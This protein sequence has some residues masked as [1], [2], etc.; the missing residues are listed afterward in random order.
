M[1]GKRTRKL[2]LAS[3]GLVGF[4]L[5][6]ILA[7]PLWFPWLLRPIAGARGVGY[8]DYTR[9][10]YSRFELTDVTF[11]NQSTVLFAKHLEG[12]VPSIWL[13]R[14]YVTRDNERYA[15]VDDWKLQIRPSANK[16]AQ[17]AASSVSDQYNKVVRILAQINRLLPHALLRNG[18]IQAGGELVQVPQAAW[19]DQKL[20]GTVTWPKKK[21]QAEVIADLRP[22]NGSAV[23]VIS[24]SLPFEAKVLITEQGNGLLL[25]ST[26]SWL[27]SEF[28]ATAHFGK[29]GFTPQTAELESKSFSIPAR[30]LGLEGYEN[31]KGGLLAHWLT[32]HF[33][34]ELTAQASP[35]D[36]AQLP[37]VNIDLSATGNTESA[38]VQKFKM[39]A[40]WLEASL[41]E[42]TTIQYTSPYLT[43]Q[44]ILQ[45]ALNLEEQRW[46]G[47][48]GKLK[49][50][51]EFRPGQG[52]LPDSTFTLSGS[53]LE[54]AELTA[55]AQAQEN[56]QEKALHGIEV[57]NLTV[58]GELVWP[59]LR[60]TQARAET[61]DG[62]TLALQGIA[63]LGSRMIH[64]GQIS[65]Q[66]GYL[67]QFL[68]QGFEYAQ[69]K[70][71]AT[72]N[73]P[74]TNLTHS[75]E[76]QIK[77]LKTPL[78]P[79]MDLSGSW[80]G[81][82][83]RLDPVQLSLH[84]GKSSVDLNGAVDLAKEAKVLRM[85]SLSMTNAGVQ[86][87]A[88]KGPF[89]VRWI[90][91]GTGTTK[92]GR[93]Q[94]TPL[95]LS[96]TAGHIE[97]A[98]DLLWPGQGQLT[99]KVED[100]RLEAF[101][102]LLPWA[103]NRAFVRRLE[104]EGGW[105]NGPAVFQMTL[106]GAARV[107]KNVSLAVDG[108][109]RGQLDGLH[110]DAL[111]VSNGNQLV[112][113]LN[114]TLP[115]KLRLG[116]TNGWLE[117]DAKAPLALHADISPE[118]F[119]DYF[120]TAGLSLQNP[121]L[122]AQLEGTLERPKGRV[123]FAA[124]KM[125][126]TRTNQNLPPFENV[127]LT[128]V[129][130]QTTARVDSLSFEIAKQLVALH[131]ELPLDEKFWSAFPKKLYLPDWK[132]AKAEIELNK[133][134]LAAFGPYLPRIMSPEGE[135][136]GKLGLV[137]G[138]QLAGA[139]T[140]SNA[141]TYPIGNIGA[142]RDIL[143]RLRFLERKAL[144][145]ATA[146]VGGNPMPV[147][148][149][150]DMSGDQW[151]SG[152]L[153]PFEMKV[154]A[155]KAPLSRTPELILKSDLNVTVSYDG[156]T[157]VTIS[158]NVNLR[159]GFYLRD[160]S[161]LTSGKISTPTRRPPYFSIEQEPLADWRLRMTVT[162]EKFLKV[163]SPLFNGVV[164]T[165]LR[166]QGTLRE[167]LATGELKVNSG[168]IRF[169]FATMPITQGLIV[170]TSENP[171]RPQLTVSAAAR[172][173]G[174]DIKMD[175]SGFA[176]KPVIQFSSTPALSSEQI[177][178]MVSAGELPRGELTFS[179]TQKAQRLALFVG[180]DLL[181]ELGFS[182]D[183]NRLTIRSGEDISEAGRPTYSVEYKLQKD[184]SV[185]GEYDRFNDF[186]L[187]LKWRVFSR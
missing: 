82:Q 1:A 185:I 93:L 60:L 139:L 106:S 114:G 164:S 38:T 37:P 171:Y 19:D 11:T 137:P 39:V 41:S 28:V 143:V 3:G 99:A 136:S 48:K 80:K 168:E 61:P 163:R 43:D 5:V 65:Y 66:G 182:G 18:S 50:Q 146:D 92:T 78:A 119:A 111:S 68:P 73:G 86:Q 121:E 44:T 107:A 130:D 159:D 63:D 45:L 87:L 34:V 58:Q 123:E 132:K 75:G 88:S 176:D 167:P 175:L 84:L 21:Q 98:G 131:G 116:N 149:T 91:T 161:D 36:G 184:L 83:F 173:F 8:A 70:L 51:V 94:L 186:N 108:H 151:L 95:S 105:S 96:G 89:E 118:A 129:V 46:V 141:R 42:G 183:A 64:Y 31:V 115:V 145:E 187:M 124:K 117:T 127:R 109:W 144:I 103:T 22:G 158:G 23:R 53:G 10:G 81:E 166:L 181:S 172:T 134:Q 57:K 126:I 76:I 178:L 148:G 79:V 54:L 40:P 85:V 62:S 49:G 174:Y 77:A 9:K 120:K 135:I 155:A 169:P 6:L 104:F 24:K 55:F 101:A 69:T 59:E 7:M 112:A 25:Q 74:W 29:Q 97:A 35:A 162:G 160:L 26:N 90:P 17:R 140:V 56:R 13:W 30:E 152:Q 153:P 102:N 133:A 154:I 4:L 157:P 47:A 20:S 142:V 15:A 16:S 125:Q 128:G 150:I 72:M 71:S 180:K 14:L 122:H 33:T 147:T 52:A 179:N 113:T 67:R 156:K 27:T 138:G 170:L 2:L 32:N 177:L 12:N 110:V 100:L 165:A